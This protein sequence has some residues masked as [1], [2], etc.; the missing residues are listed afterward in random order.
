METIRVPFWN[1]GLE[2]DGVHVEDVLFSV[3]SLAGGIHSSAN[4]QPR[5]HH[6]VTAG[7]T[8]G[9]RICFLVHVLDEVLEGS[10]L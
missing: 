6:K 10:C 3:V 1:H 5:I 4:P 9:F 8:G 2:T 7:P